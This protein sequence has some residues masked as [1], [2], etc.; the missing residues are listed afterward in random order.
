MMTRLLVFSST[1]EQSRAGSVVVKALDESGLDC[2]G[3]P[4]P[5]LLLL[6]SQLATSLPQ[7]TQ[8]F[9]YL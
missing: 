5:L 8:I 7:L 2:K 1:A 6:P 9:L 3:N 4:S